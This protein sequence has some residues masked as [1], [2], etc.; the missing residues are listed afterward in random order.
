M[1]VT[2]VN[3]RQEMGIMKTV[4]LREAKGMAKKARPVKLHK[5][6]DFKD[7]N[8]IYF[9]YSRFSNIYFISHACSNVMKLIHKITFSVDIQGQAN[10]F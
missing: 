9:M 10:K 7:T 6:S 3:M 4:R 8:S 5:R 2:A 1:G